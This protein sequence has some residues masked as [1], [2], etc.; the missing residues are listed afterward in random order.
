[1]VKMKL[2]FTVFLDGESVVNEL[3]D[4]MAEAMRKWF[5]EKGCMGEVPCAQWVER[6]E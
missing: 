3:Q 4:V 6:I 1:M 2:N 5:E